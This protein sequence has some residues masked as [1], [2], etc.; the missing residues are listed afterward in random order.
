MNALLEESHS[1]GFRCRQSVEVARSLRVEA[2]FVANKGFLTEGLT[3]VEGSLRRSIDSS[4]GLAGQWGGH[5]EE[6]K[7]VRFRDADASLLDLLKY[8]IAVEVSEIK[9]PKAVF[10]RTAISAAFKLLNGL[11]RVVLSVLRC[12]G[13][14]L[15]LAN[16]AES[17]DI[18]A[19]LNGIILCLSQILDVCTLIPFS[20]VASTCDNINN[21]MNLYSNHEKNGNLV[22]TAR[23]DFYSSACWMA[24]D[25]LCSIN[26]TWPTLAV[27]ESVG[28]GHVQ[29]IAYLKVVEVILCFAVPLNAPRVAKGIAALFDEETRCSKVNGSAA[30]SY[31]KLP[32]S[33]P[34]VIVA[35][36]KVRFLCSAPTYIVAQA[37]S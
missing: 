12:Y 21:R 33:K 36:T 1:R 9:D 3:N 6:K 30:G 17:G 29:E 8:A 16:G 15:G 27:V 20:A 2:N 22:K 28:A 5:S 37:W 10:N 7:G 18:P 35:L 26:R 19:V 31:L 23:L 25:I 4:S 13:G 14:S 11:Q 34:P 24:D 32:L